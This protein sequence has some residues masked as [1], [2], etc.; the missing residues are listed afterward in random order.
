MKIILTS[1]LLAGIVFAVSNDVTGGT[2]V[3]PSEQI[4]VDI[5]LPADFDF[6]AAQLELKQART[7]G[8]A[9]RARELSQMIHQYWLEHREMLP[10]PVMQGKHNGNTPEPMNENPGSRTA[11]LWGNDIRIDPNDGVYDVAIAS[12]STGELHALSVWFDGANY[13]VLHHISQ[14]DGENWSV[15]W[16]LNAAGYSFS[17]PQIFVSQDTII[18]SYILY[19]QSDGYYRNWVRVCGPGPVDNPIY[20]GSPTG[21]FQSTPFTCLD[22]CTD[23]VIY[24]DDHYLYA[25][26]VASEPYD[27]VYAMAAVSEDIDVSSWEVGPTQLNIATGDAYYSNTRIAFGSISD[28]M[29]IVAGAHPN[30]YPG[31]YDE[32]IAAWLS[33]NYGSSWSYYSPITPWDDHF[34]QFDPAVAGSHTNTNWVVLHTTADTSTGADPDIDN[35]YSTNDGTDWTT[36]YWISSYENT[37]ADVW[38]DNNSTGFYGACLQ[39]RSGNVEHV[40]YKDCPVSDPTAWTTSV[41][42]NDDVNGVL[43]D[44]YGPSVTFN[45]GALNEACIAWT[46]YDPQYSI[47]FDTYSATAAEERNDDSRPIAVSLRPNPSHTAARLSYVVAREG[48]VRITLYD[49]TGRLVKNLTNGTQTAGD[50]ALT[51]D[52]AELSAGVYFVRIETP[53][54]EANVPMTIVK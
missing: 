5:E 3:T 31:S 44:V 26:W 41:L 37:H 14:D 29:Y 1:L 40:R 2:I 23:G 46:N 42:V 24:G 7:Q 48:A 35:T 22:V 33:T 11:P 10:D 36:I 16:D 19:R 6:D 45:E 47:W 28:A 50:Y 8:N 18:Q 25:T 49:A 27:T 17:Y 12:T 21:D 32:F 53:T 13:H 30:F 54:T 9:Q 15:V 52:N 38:V 4:A 43:S 51:L 20:W 34:D 39:D